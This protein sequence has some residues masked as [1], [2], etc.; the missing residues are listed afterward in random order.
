MA[1]PGRLPRVVPPGAQLVVDGKLI[2]AGVSGPCTSTLIYETD[3]SNQTIVAMSTYTMH[4]STEAWG[5]D[6][7]EFNPD[8]WLGPDAQGLEQWMCTFSKGARMCIGQK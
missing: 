1:V 8:R 7:R 3:V 4:T 2:P 6:A 5:P